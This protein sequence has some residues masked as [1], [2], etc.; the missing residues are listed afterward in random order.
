MYLSTNWIKDFVNLDGLDLDELIHR[1]TLSTAEVEDIYHYGENISGVICAKIVSCEPHPDSKKL[2]ILKIDTGSDTLTD[3][4]C[5]APNAREG[6]IVAFATVGGRVGELEIKPITLA[7]YPSNGMC[8][9]K[10]E[11]GI[12]D[13]NTGLWELPKTTPLGV[14]IKK[15]YPIDDTVFEVDNK[16]LT[17]RPDLWG[18]YGIAREFAAISGRELKPYDKA[19]LSVYDSLPGVEINIEDTEHC[20]RYSSV[21]VDN[22]TCHESPIA[23]QIRLFYC[24]MRGINLLTDLTN[25]L[26]LELGQPMHAFDRRRVDKVEIKRFDKPFVFQTLDEQER[27]IDENMLMICSGG[28]PVA[29]AGI[30][31]GLASSILDDTTELLL[32]S[33]N[34]DG[35]SVRKSSTRLGLRT[36]ASARYEKMLDPE[37][38]TAAIERFVYLLCNIDSGA[39]IVSRLSDCYPTKYPKIELEFDRAYVDRYTGIA[40]DDTTIEKTL[41]AL[42]FGV[43]HN[44]DNYKVSVPSWRSTKDVTIKADIIEEITRIYGYDNFEIKTTRSPLK[45]R[46]EDPERKTDRLIKDLLVR[47]FGLHEVNSYIWADGKAYGELGIDVEENISI[48][49]AMT[50]DNSVIRNSIMPSLLVF[51]AKNKGYANEYGMFEI[52]R[53][54]VG[55]KENGYAD[56]RKVLGISLTSR[57]ASEK[58]LFFK[59]KNIL[60]E[61]ASLKYREFEY[62]NI[63]PEHNWQHPKNTVSVSLDKVKMGTL[64]TLHPTTASLLDKK[65]H[66]VTAELDLGLFCEAK[67]GELTYAEPSKFPGMDYDITLFLGQNERYADVSALWE[68]ADMPFLCGVNVVDTFVLYKKE[69]AET[70]LPPVLEAIKEKLSKLTKVTVRFHFGSNERTLKQDEVQPS[71]DEIIE[72]LRKSGKML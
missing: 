48:I 59:L 67:S 60:G 39:K 22:V 15:L 28:E 44:G 62:A 43:E 63:E 54:V 41:L 12:S 46:L 34:F 6:L 18:H 7:G 58:D 42:G 31:G 33:A 36:D 10:K 25:Y 70:L 47:R 69:I 19:D 38:T 23:M 50:V 40:I 5:G 45:P 52:G 4:V 13:D 24:G 66:T 61:I 16:S 21:K 71:I 32:E 68:N 11:L 26:M 8:C 9:S 27:N 53:V 29:I 20:Y 72:K 2:H 56:E 37:L 55:K 57:T 1:F 49:N 17:N 64:C 65:S 30:M 14:D 3:C 35:V 51:A